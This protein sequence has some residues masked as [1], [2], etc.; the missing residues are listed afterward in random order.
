MTNRGH[1]TQ[2][3]KAELLL[4]QNGRCAK[5]PTKLKAGM[6]EFDHIQ[7]LQFEGDNELDN[8][9]ALCTTGNRCHQAKTRAASKASAHTERLAVG[10]KKSKRGFRGWK[11]FDGTIVFAEGKR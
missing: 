3:Q 8:W 6:F 10:G 4:K 1:L 2:K 7:D 11:R 9:Q 5:C